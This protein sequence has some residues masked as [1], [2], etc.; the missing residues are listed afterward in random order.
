MDA[1]IL[2]NPSKAPTIIGRKRDLIQ[3]EVAWFSRTLI[4]RLTNP[5]ILREALHKLPDSERPS[6]L[7]GLGES[8]KAVFRLYSRLKAQ[9]VART[10][11]IKVSI[12]A[13]EA[14]GL[15]KILNTVLETFLDTLE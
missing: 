10:Y 6:F 14:Y 13:G 2:I 8:D 9:E 12:Q 7:R 15:A 4:L 3:G 1:R 11:I 5:K